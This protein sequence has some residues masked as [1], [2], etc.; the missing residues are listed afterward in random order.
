MTPTCQCGNWTTLA[1]VVLKSEV[2][3]RQKGVRVIYFQKMFGARQKHVSH[4]TKLK[5]FPSFSLQ[6]NER[7]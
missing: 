1:A 2:S 7:L 4:K 5:G 3:G 6:F